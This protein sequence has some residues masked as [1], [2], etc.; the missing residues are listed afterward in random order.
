MINVLM[1]VSNNSL[2]VNPNG[3]VE[4]DVLI[5]I[6]KSD[7]FNDI[8]SFNFFCFSLIRRQRPSSVSHSVWTLELIGLAKKRLF[9][10]HMKGP[11]HFSEFV[12]FW[13]TPILSCP[14]V[15]LQHVL[16]LAP[17]TA[18]NRNFMNTFDNFDLW[19]LVFW[20]TGWLVKRYIQ[21]RRL[22]FPLAE[23]NE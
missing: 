11:W 5:K 4:D 15:K 9:S 21:W 7:I 17:V 2:L 6:K 16:P 22:C 23:N 19:V 8:E 13:S 1:N 14:T 3:N 12:F 18:L 10:I 20:W